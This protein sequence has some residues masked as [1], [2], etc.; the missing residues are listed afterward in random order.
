MRV[1]FSAV[2]EGPLIPG[3]CEEDGFHGL[4]PALV[5]PPA[6][7]FPDQVQFQKAWRLYQTRPFA[8]IMPL[9][10]WPAVL[11]VAYLGLLV[12]GLICSVTT[13]QQPRRRNIRIAT[14]V[15]A[16]PALLAVLLLA[17]LRFTIFRQPPTLVELQRDFS[18]KR[19]DLET[20]VHMSDEDLAFSRIAPDFLYRTS[21]NPSETGVHMVGD[22]KAGLPRNRWDAY[23]KIYSRN[24][25]KLGI[26]RDL[27]RD[28]FIMVDSV[29][30]LNR[31]HTSGYLYC[32]STGPINGF[33]FQPCILGQE[34]GE[35]R[36]DPKTREEGYSYRKL[37]DRWYA[38]DEGP[39]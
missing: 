36:Y 25:I 19:T 7:C 28:A 27:S 24:G 32:S 39:S 8:T 16:A 4:G 3:Q 34:K 9:I 17:L 5:S 35:R 15:L 20:I 38:Y 30:L 10:S 14:A 23:R 6:N 18:A 11:G 21:E 13:R 2:D 31:G 12:T 26:Q 22:P 29:G 33:R 1:N 37:A